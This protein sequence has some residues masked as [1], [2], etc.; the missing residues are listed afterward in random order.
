MLKATGCSLEG[1]GIRFAGLAADALIT[2]SIFLKKKVTMELHLPLQTLCASR[3]QARENSALF[4]RARR[5]TSNNIRNRISSWIANYPGAQI[6]DANTMACYFNPFP[7]SYSDP[8]GNHD[9]GS[10]ERSPA[11]V[12]YL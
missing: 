5:Y 1:E 11:V 12:L 8:E 3:E 9:S 7:S 10:R 2:I 4:F 6:T